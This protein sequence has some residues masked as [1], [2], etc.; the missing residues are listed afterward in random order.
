MGALITSM[1]FAVELVKFSLNIG[2]PLLK[3][4]MLIR[5]IEY[6]VVLPK[7]VTSTVSY[8]HFLRSFT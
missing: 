7:N 2:C 4:I 5:W 6:Y 3:H 8:R 1:Y